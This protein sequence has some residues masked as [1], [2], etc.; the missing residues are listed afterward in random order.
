MIISI[1]YNPLTFPNTFFEENRMSLL[2]DFKENTHI[3]AGEA[4]KIDQA[5]FERFVEKHGRDAAIGYF[6]A[7]TEFTEVLN[8]ILYTNKYDV[9]WFPETKSNVHGKVSNLHN[10]LF[11]FSEDNGHDLEHL[12]KPTSPRTKCKGF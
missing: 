2:Q 9:T 11:K 6:K 3:F 7:L 10:A 4:N 8:R 12:N 5:A 1:G